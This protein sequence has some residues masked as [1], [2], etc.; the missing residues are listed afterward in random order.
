MESQTLQ[1]KNGVVI[2]NP[3]KKTFKVF[4]NKTQTFYYQSRDL[5]Y[6]NDYYHARKVRITCE[7]CGRQSYEHCLTLHQNKP[8]CKRWQEKREKEEAK[9]QTKP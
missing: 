8:I 9:Q 2:D 4:S 7:R 3:A 1:P 5:T 6:Y